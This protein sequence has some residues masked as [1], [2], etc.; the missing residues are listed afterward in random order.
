[1]ARAFATLRGVSQSRGSLTLR[2]LTRRL[3]DHIFLSERSGQAICSHHCY[4]FS[5]MADIVPDESNFQ[6]I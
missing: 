6:W 3:A 4:A 5:E 1:M 2:D